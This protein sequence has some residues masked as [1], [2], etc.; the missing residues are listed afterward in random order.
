[1]DFPQGHRSRL[2]Q[3]DNYNPF[4]Q[5]QSQL[6]EYPNEEIL[7]CFNFNS[8]YKKIY[9]S[10]TI[11]SLKKLQENKLADFSMISGRVYKKII[12]IYKDNIE[13]EKESPKLFFKKT[14]SFIKCIPSLKYIERFLK[15]YETNRKNKKNVYFLKICLDI[16]ED[17]FKTL[18]FP[19][20]KKYT[21][22]FLEVAM[23][24]YAKLSEENMKFIIDQIS[25]M[26]TISKKFYLECNILFQ[27]I[28]RIQ[29]FRV[30]NDT[31]N[32]RLLH[33]RED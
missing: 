28:T 26:K 1:M 33:E 30:Q 24:F 6:I 22:N 3:I 13:K 18:D 23:K 12:E 16:Y 15:K 2:S 11:H 5:A 25:Y 31:R 17:Y 20:F 14:K 9:G 29:K 27:F 7:N 4:I 8:A 32:F 19:M 10:L 21:R